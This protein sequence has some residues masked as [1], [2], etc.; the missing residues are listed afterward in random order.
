[1]RETTRTTEEETKSERGEECERAISRAGKESERV[2]ERDNECEK[3][4]AIER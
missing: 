4:R 3:Q 2:S 1:M